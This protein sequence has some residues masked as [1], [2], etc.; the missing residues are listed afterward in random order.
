[1]VFA[2]F[3]IMFNYLV[4]KAMVSSTAAASENESGRIFFSAFLTTRKYL[5]INSFSY[6]IAIMNK[7]MIIN[8]VTL[9]EVRFV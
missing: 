9:L 3:F 6:V 2:T 1:M 4:F 8:R 5:H 7:A